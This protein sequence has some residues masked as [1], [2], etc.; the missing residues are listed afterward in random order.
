MLTLIRSRFVTL[1]FSVAVTCFSGDSQVKMFDGT[2]KSI[3]QLQPGD[4]AAGSTQNE[5]IL[6]LDSHPSQQGV[7]DSL[8]R[9]KHN[10][11]NSF[12]S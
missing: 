12:R 5:I 3:A 2:Y 1:H 10:Y 9:N 7:Y 8:Y 11:S 6:M 4:Y